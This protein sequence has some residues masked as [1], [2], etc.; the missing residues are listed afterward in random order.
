[1]GRRQ[2]KCHG[3]DKRFEVVARFIYDRFGKKIK[4]IAD[5]AGGQGVLTRLLNKKYGYESEVIDPRGYTLVGVSSRQSEYDS[6]M[7]NYYDLIIGLHPDEA[8]REVAKSALTRP[9]LI[10]PCCNFWTREKKLGSKELVSAICDY[11]KENK[12]EYEI[13]NFDFAGPKNVGI[14]TKGIIENHEKI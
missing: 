8:T 11:F 3:D 10:V 4:Y 2:V 14:L 12:I 13:I 7:A 1:M 6:T 9:V 5:V